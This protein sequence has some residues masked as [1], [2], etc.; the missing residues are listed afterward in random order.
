MVGVVNKVPKVSSYYMYYY[1]RLLVE[2]SIRSIS[3]ITRSA[4]WE[5]IVLSHV[6]KGR[7]ITRGEA[8]WN[9]SF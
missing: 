9:L 3:R 1:I 8:E 6:L 4:I 5:I 2:I 7:V